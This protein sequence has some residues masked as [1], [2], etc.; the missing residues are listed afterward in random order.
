[1]RQ[2]RRLTSQLG[3]EAKNTGSWT[4]TNRAGYSK[5]RNE[6]T[7]LTRRARAA[8]SESFAIK[9]LGLRST[10]DFW[11]HVKHTTGNMTNTNL[12]IPAAKVGAHF[13]KLLTPP[14]NELFDQEFL[15]QAETV[16][17]TPSQAQLSNALM[18]RYLVRKSRRLLNA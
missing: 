3:S 8:S 17:K 15:D 5:M 2:L 10:S 6:C 13:K 14:D 4:E 7:D 9:P 1:M 18:T 16:L 12:T 11:A